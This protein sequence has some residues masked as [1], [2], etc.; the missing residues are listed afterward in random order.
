MYNIG[1]LKHFAT[2]SWYNS[3]SLSISSHFDTENYTWIFD[4]VFL[5]DFW[6]ILSQK[7]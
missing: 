7:I 5:S 2:K 3:K 1:V 6:E 4:I